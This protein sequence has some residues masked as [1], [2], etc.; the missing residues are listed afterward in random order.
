MIL[1]QEKD[2]QEKF[3]LYLWVGEAGSWNRVVVED[4]GSLANVFHS[5]DAL[6]TGSMR[7]HVFS[8]MLL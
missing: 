3:D 4:V 7:K 8:C 2:L 1:S 5:A 6:C